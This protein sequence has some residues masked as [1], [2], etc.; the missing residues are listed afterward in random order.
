VV[1]WLHGAILQLHLAPLKLLLGS[2]AWDVDESSSCGGY[3]G[4]LG[5]GVCGT[6]FDVYGPLFIVLLGPTHR[7]CG[8]LR[9][10]S[11][12]RTLIRLRLEDL[13]GNELRVCYD[14]ETEFLTGLRQK[15]YLELGREVRLGRVTARATGLIHF[16]YPGRSG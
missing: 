15:P 6:K 8:V 11:I 14:M 13:E 3:L 2:I 1:L 16:P 10:L 9:F 12:N 5:F 4:A 7:G